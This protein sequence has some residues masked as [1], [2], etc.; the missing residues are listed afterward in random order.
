MDGVEA[1]LSP[2]FVGGDVPGGGLAHAG[3]HQ[4]HGG[5]VINEL[6]GVLVP[7]DDNGIAALGGV[8]P[9]HGAQQVVCLPALQLV[10][11]NVHGIQH[12]FQHRHLDGQLLRHSLALSLVLSVGLVAEG[13]GAHVKG[14]RQPLGLLLVQQLEQDIQK[15]ENG[16]GGQALPG[17]QVLADTIK[18]PVDDG[19]AINNHKLHRGHLAF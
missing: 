3:G 16:V 14:H 6:Q 1:V 13:G 19:I 8:H 4:L 18:G 12:L 10:A 15:S 2:E 5:V 9:G 11:A 17:G 7:G